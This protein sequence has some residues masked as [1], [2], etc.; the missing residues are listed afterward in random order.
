M[1][2]RRTLQQRFR[3]VLETM[4]RDEPQRVGEFLEMIRPAQ[5]AKFGD[6]QANFCMPLAKLVGKSPRELASEVI[7]AVKLD[8]LCLPP[9]VAGPGFINLRVREEYLDQAL[10]AALKSDRLDVPQAESPKTYVVDF[11]SPNVAKPMHVGHIRSTVIGDALQRTLRLLGHRVITD[12][13]LGDWGTQFGMI[14]YGYKHFVDAEAYKQRPVPELSRLYRL[15]HRLVDYFETR[16]ALPALEKKIALETQY[17]EDAKQQSVSATGADKKKADKDIAAR[18][19]SLKELSDEVQHTRDKLAAMEADAAFMAQIKAHSDVAQAV[20][21]ETAKL[22]AGDEENLRLWKEFLPH[23]RDE[24]RRV[25]DRLSITH[26]VEY[27]ESFYHDMLA[28]VVDDLEKRGLAKKS[29]GATVVFLEGFETPMLIRKRDGAYLYS[30]TD[31]ATIFFR[32][33]EFKPD[34]VLY[35]VDH[36]QSEHFQKLFA[37]AKL[38][39]VPT[40]L[41]HISFGTVLGDD[42][43]PFKTRQGDTIGLEGLL[44]EAENRAYQVV[45]QIDD[46]K[47]GG[48]ELNEAQRLQVAKVIGIAA[49]KYA[50]LSQNRTSDYT[51]S[52]DKMLAISGNSAV[53]AQYSYARVK[54]IFARGG[55][56]QKALRAAVEK[57][58]LSDPV[59]RALALRLLRF[60]EAIE[61]VVVDYRP[62]ILTAYLYDLASD[63][64]RFFDKCPVLKAEPESL[65]QSRLALCDLTART[66]ELGLSLL[67]IHVVERM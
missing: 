23:C 56:D 7:A 28:G 58:E 35:V 43:K 32:E 5:E 40:D 38:C 61:E 11:S 4:L 36:R 16:D 54:S 39:G 60:S 62:N 25:Y 52:F 57:F 10:K 17:L 33:K 47:A 29:E 19:R 46:A 41:R 34:V 50:D 48:A 49:I 13:H 6:Y 67:G 9:E 20:L 51:F 45:C 15:V 2:L 55:V 26:D 12:N 30:T 21:A 42:G 27:G 53:A 64:A 44:D 65:R 37:A 1:N 8:D 63:Y 66:I 59:E 31:L 3:P 14:I 24:I 18:Q 22:H